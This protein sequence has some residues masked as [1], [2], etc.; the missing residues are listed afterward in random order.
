MLKRKFYATA[1]IS[2]FIFAAV[3]ADS[4][5]AVGISI[6]ADSL[7]HIPGHHFDAA[8]L[9][10]CLPF[11]PEEDLK[12]APSFHLNKAAAEFVKK[13]NKKNG[14]FL[15]KAKSKCGSY[16]KLID[17][18]FCEQGIPVELKYLAFIE[19]GLK[20]NMV[21]SSGAIGPW[22]L[23]PKVARQYGL[24]TGPHD[25]RLDYYKSTKAAANL[26]KDLYAKYDDW[27][28]VIAAYNAGPGRINKAIKRAGTNNYWT[29]Q[30]FL[31]EET[32]KHVKKFI[33]VH[34]QFEGHGSVATMTKAETESH[35][36]AVIALV[37]KQ[38]RC[39]TDQYLTH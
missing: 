10:T 15:N 14:H 22:A 39:A 23:M 30:K 33:A 19:S 25:E 13:Y 31:P 34:Y 35:V 29:L 8:G 27:I 9:C 6:N 32:R 5:K 17:S 26:L 20:L 11:M 24:R 1:F 7:Y 2:C 12:Q 38:Q 28:L 37:E 18:V 3:A 4:P 16:F 21:S 36:K